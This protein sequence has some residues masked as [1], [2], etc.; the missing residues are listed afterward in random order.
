MSY[1]TPPT[2]F[3]ECFYQPEWYDRDFFYSP[4]GIREFPDH[5]C[6]ITW[7]KSLPYIQNSRNAI[8]IGCRDGEYTRYLMNNFK[9]VYCFDPRT[10]PYFP[11]NVDLS[12][13]THWGIPLGDQPHSVRLGKKPIPA[14][15]VFYC[16]DDFNF[17]NVDYIKLDTDGYELANIKG[18]LKTITRDW[19][20]L[21]LEVFFE[22]QTIEFV[23]KELGYTVK[24]VCPRGWDHVL[25]KEHNV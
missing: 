7:L 16:L 18:G 10:R 11:Y 1:P 12:K 13:A 17:Q 4:D 23:T 5:H 15:S 14:Q 21:V 20:V 3:A 19:P 8:D 25:V 24:A 9:H 2:E 22:K 6:K